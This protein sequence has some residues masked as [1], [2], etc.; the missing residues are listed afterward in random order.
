LIVGSLIR[1]DKSGDAKYHE[2]DIDS[3]LDKRYVLNLL[4]D[5]YC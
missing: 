1:L 3:I 5:L 2:Q 4:P